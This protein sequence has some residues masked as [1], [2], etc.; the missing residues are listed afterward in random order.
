MIHNLTPEQ[1]KKIKTREKN[2]TIYGLVMAV[3]ALIFFS[4]PSI[5]QGTEN[6]PRLFLIWA[7]ALG[8]F[9]FLIFLGRKQ[10]QDKRPLQLASEDKALV[11][12]SRGGREEIPYD[13][14]LKMGIN[15]DLEGKVSAIYFRTKLKRFIILQGFEDLTGLAAELEAKISDPARV[16]RSQGKP[17][18]KRRLGGIALI[19][20]LVALF[21]GVFVGLFYLMNKIGLGDLLLPIAFVWMGISRFALNRHDRNSRITGILLILGG[22]AYG[23]FKLL[24]Y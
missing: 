11:L 6:F 9:G 19:I 5:T 13:S 21:M 23:A 12:I 16:E 7:V 22:L 10:A 15:S 2:M 17:S 3:T 20:G 24:G 4:I 1:A 18:A 14:I 8:F